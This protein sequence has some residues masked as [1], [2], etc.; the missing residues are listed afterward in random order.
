M[1]RIYLICI[2][3]LLTIS[4]TIPAKA[5]MERQ[6]ANISQAVDDAF[7][8][9]TLV[10]QSTG[11]QL[12]SGILNVS[13]MHSFGMATNK[14]IKNFF[15]L[16]H[17]QNVRIGLD[18]GFTDWWSLGIGRSSLANVID[19]RMKFRLLRQNPTNNVPFGLSLKGD[20]SVITQANNRPFNDDLSTFVSVIVSRKFNETISLQI[21]PM[22]AHFNNFILGDENTYFAMGIGAEIHLNKRFAL[23]AEYYPVFGNRPAGTENAF[24][25][26]LNIKT[27]GHVFQL[28]FASTRWHIPQF[29]ITRNDNNFWAGDFRFGFN[30][31]R[32]FGLN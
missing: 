26:G 20:V 29:I 9:P 23:M 11:H 24:S 25:L 22:Y 7:W 17:I 1:K 19:L 27:G 2:L 12:G 28:F 10:T 32:I 13:I 15:G 14:P 5:Q 6:R 8:S 3:S 31:N 4:N 30:V 21:S 18:Y 16:D